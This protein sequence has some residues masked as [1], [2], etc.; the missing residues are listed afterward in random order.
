MAALQRE[1]LR[2]AAAN[3][4]D[5]AQGLAEGLGAR[6]GQALRVTD[7]RE[8]HYYRSSNTVYDGVVA[9][10]SPRESAL[11]PNEIKVAATAEVVPY[12]YPY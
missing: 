4:L 7:Q 12:A 10:S 1:A 8:S 5:R 2:L 6:V 3:A 11:A 9:E